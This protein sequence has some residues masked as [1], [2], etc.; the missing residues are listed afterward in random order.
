V[1]VRVWWPASAELE[2]ICPAA[3]PVQPAVLLN[4][5]VVVWGGIPDRGWMSRHL[6]QAASIIKLSEGTAFNCMHEVV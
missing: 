3:Y 5:L 1:P 6:R 2:H 4:W